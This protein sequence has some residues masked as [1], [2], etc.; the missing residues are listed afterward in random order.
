[1]LFAICSKDF[2]ND[3]MG[4]CQ[5]LN[6][7]AAIFFEICDRD[8]LKT[9]GMIKSFI[10]KMKLR[11][12]YID[13]VYEYHLKNNVLNG[14]IKQHLPKLYNHLVRKL[15]VQ[16]EM[17][18]TAWIMTMFMGFIHQK[19]LLLTILDNFV[20]NSKDNM[21]WHYLYCVILALFK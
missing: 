21:Q 10:T 13:K 14:L 19:D 11:G 3:K 18:T 17:I 20:L 5:G 4:Y 8:E 9:Y 12:M 7:M 6:Y 1:M 15:G 16:F 2:P